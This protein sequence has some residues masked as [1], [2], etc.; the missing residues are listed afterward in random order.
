MRPILALAF[1]L[2][3]VCSASAQP[4]G[5]ARI[6]PGERTTGWLAVPGG[7]DGG[8]VRLPVT[9]ITGKE[10]GPTVAIL[11][12]IHG[13]E[14]VPI[15]ALHSLPIRIDPAAVR[16]TIVIVHIANPPAFRRRTIFYGPDDWKNLNRVFPGK[17][18]GTQ[19]E[20]IAH[21]I[22]TQIIDRVQAMIDVH[23]GDGNE[24]LTP[25][26][27]FSAD[28]PGADVAARSR[29]MA[30]AFGMSVVKVSRDPQ[31]KADATQYTTNTAAARGV[32]AIGVEL[33]SRSRVAREE[34]ETVQNGL[35]NVLRHLRALPGEPAAAEKPMFMTASQSVR[36]TAEGLWFP[37]VQA[38][39]PIAKEALVG[40]IRDPFGAVLAEIRSPLTGYVVYV[41]TTP[42]TVAGETLASIGVLAESDAAPLP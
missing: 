1:L 26:V 37:A 34:V 41:T 23:C 40:T 18:D 4:F 16:G 9:V 20:R 28:A 19:S 11:A 39:Q 12:G 8:D 29:A 36:S 2:T 22:T 10:A 13:V 15:V 7:A 32:A 35:L 3:A 27:S 17:A 30:L 24:E 38:G 5:T 21:A 33:G 6:A 25:Y 31:R 14:Y 42:P